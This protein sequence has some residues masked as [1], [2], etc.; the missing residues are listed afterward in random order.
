[1][2]LSV[3]F[4]VLMLLWLVFGMWAG[5]APGQP[6][7]YRNW[8]PGLLQFILLGLLGWAVFGAAVR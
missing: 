3:A 2:P 5:Y 4:W 6:Y 1:M 8:G 7:T